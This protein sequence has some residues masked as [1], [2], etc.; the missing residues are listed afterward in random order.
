MIMFS[1]EGA[2]GYPARALASSS[3]VSPIGFYDC[4]QDADALF[5][6]TRNAGATVVSE[7]ADAFWGDRVAPRVGLEPTT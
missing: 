6:R 1:P 3:I 7:L 5:K 2:R 4:C